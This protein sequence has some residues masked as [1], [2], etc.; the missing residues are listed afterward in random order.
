MSRI[1]ARASLLAMVGAAALAGPGPVR[2]TAAAPADHQP[3]IRGVVLADR[4][5]GATARPLT[6]ALRLADGAPAATLQLEVRGFAIADGAAAGAVSGTATLI[7]NRGRRAGR[8]ITTA[9][10]PP[11]PDPRGRSHPGSWRVEL[12]D[13]GA[14]VI[15][16][17]RDTG[18]G[19]GADAAPRPRAGSTLLTVDL[20]PPSLVGGLEVRAATLALNVDPAG[21]PTATAAAVNPPREGR[22]AVVSRWVP[23][24]PAGAADPAHAVRRSIAVA[25]R[26]PVARLSLGPARQT[27]GPG[28]VVSL[29]LV[30]R[31]GD[32]VAVDLRRN[33]HPFRSYIVGGAA[34]PIAVQLSRRDIGR[35]IVFTAVPLGGA[36]GAPV[37]AR[38][39]VAR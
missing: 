39:R 16:V 5:P 11:A 36:R 20:P 13:E 37:A 9:G 21:A 10:P 12:A 29:R 30:N 27:A 4:A 15:A 7:T 1:G 3:G 23:Y 26:R 22:F 19:P 28:E 8:P 17:D 34:V 31:S 35:T 24:G 32:R 25:V 38:V 6:L 18:L 33:G 2:D 14:V